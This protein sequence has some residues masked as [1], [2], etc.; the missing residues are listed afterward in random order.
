MDFAVIATGGKQYRVK[1]GQKIKVEKLP[2]EAGATHIFNEILLIENGADVKIGMPHV[3][4]AS[5]T[6]KLERT[7]KAPKVVVVKYKAKSRYYKK[8]GHRQPFTEI[9]ITD[10][11]G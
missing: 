9:T 1:K 2:G 8:R 3:K 7:S 10:I 11:K 6:A 4:G 5:V